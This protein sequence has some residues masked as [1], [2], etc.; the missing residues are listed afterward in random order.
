MQLSTEIYA[1]DKAEEK[2]FKT[3]SHA[4]SMVVIIQLSRE[5]SVVNTSEEKYFLYFSQT[6]S[7]VKN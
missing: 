6:V 4:D 2:C 1:D 3:A 7:T 5:F